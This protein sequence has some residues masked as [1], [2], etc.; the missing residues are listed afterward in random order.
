MTP[1]LSRTPDSGAHTALRRPPALHIGL[2]AIDYMLAGAPSHHSLW[3]AKTLGR[4]AK[5]DDAADHRRDGHEL[6]AEC[7]D[8][9][10]RRVDV[11]ARPRNGGGV[12]DQ[13]TVNLVGATDY[14]D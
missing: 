12:S 3:R 8:F 5:A 4:G 7:V 9:T 6:A 10:R 11:D 2:L 1:R 13:V 14:A